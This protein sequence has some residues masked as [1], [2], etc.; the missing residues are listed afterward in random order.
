MPEVLTPE[1]SPLARLMGDDPSE[2]VIGVLFNDGHKITDCD[3]DNLKPLT[4]VC[5]IFAFN[6]F[7]ISDAGLMRL[8]SLTHLKV[9]AFV[10]KTNVTD[11]GIAEFQKV[12]PNC[13]IRR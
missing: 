3:L 7:P 1:L 6:E 12:L 8:A 4:E 13:E 11:A 9:I 10:G 2:L 5:C